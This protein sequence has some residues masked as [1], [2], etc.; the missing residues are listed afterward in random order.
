VLIISHTAN[1]GNTIDFPT[2][3]KTKQHHQKKKILE[4]NKAYPKCGTPDVIL[5]PK[6][7]GGEGR[8]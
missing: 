8:G 6:L 7:R 5:R 3:G 2:K 1:P 4:K